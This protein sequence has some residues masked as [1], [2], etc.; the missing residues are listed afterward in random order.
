MCMC[1]RLQELLS[2]P[3]YVKPV[4]V[5]CL[6][7]EILLDGL[8]QDLPAASVGCLPSC[9]AWL[10]L[11]QIAV[12]H[13]LIMPLLRMTGSQSVRTQLGLCCQP[14]ICF[15]QDVQLQVLALCR[16]VTLIDVLYEH[17][18]RLFCSAEGDPYVLFQNILTQ[19]DAN[20]RRAHLVR[21]R[22]NLVL[23]HLV[24]RHLATAHLLFLSTT[25]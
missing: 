17:R 14:T 24:L 1:M 7:A 9:V 23:L 19:Q 15:G 10:R 16:F 20:E 22:L 6:P 2:L 25:A 3:Q 18:I 13:Q 12:P 4:Q 8:G 21:T 11:S 5:A